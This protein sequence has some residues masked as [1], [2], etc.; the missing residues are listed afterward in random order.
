MNILPVSSAF[1]LL[2]LIVIILYIL[3]YILYLGEDTAIA[4]VWNMDEKD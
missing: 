1:K 4:C 3:K 2:N